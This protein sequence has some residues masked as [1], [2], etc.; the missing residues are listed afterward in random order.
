MYSHSSASS[1]AMATCDTV[2]RSI[3][4]DASSHK[5]AH[6]LLLLQ[7]K[8]TL[9][10]LVRL[11]ITKTG[12]DT[13]THI[14]LRLSFSLS[15]ELYKQ[16]SQVTWLAVTEVRSASARLLAGTWHPLVS[17]I[18]TLY[19]AALIVLHGRVWYRALSLR[20]ACIGRSGI[21]LIP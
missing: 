16:K 10:M 12:G 14:I 8:M 17:V 2:S 9:M 5:E 15:L 11:F 13:H 3:T 20:Y 6:S 4:Q 18:T 7:L 21:T 19:Y 1:S